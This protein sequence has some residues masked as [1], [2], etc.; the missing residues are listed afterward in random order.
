MKI[1]CI[2]VSDFWKAYVEGNPKC[3][4]AGKTAEEAV[5]KLAIYLQIAEIKN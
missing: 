1:I 4:E 3:W 5:G 2:R